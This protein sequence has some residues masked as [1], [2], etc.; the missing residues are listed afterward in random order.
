MGKVASVHHMLV[1]DKRMESSACLAEPATLRE[2]ERER[3][4]VTAKKEGVPKCRQPLHCNPC[5][6]LAI[7]RLTATAHDCLSLVAGLSLMCLCNY[8]L[9]SQ[10]PQSFV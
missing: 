5:R 3:D 10:T 2:R 1:F 4:V 6:R 8:Y 7:G 9:N